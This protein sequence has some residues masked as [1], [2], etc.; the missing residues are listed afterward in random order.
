MMPNR[1]GRATLGILLSLWLLFLMFRDVDW[2]IFGDR[3]VSVNPVF[4][5]AA[6]LMLCADY[7]LRM[8][9]WQRMLRRAGSPIDL[10]TCA[11][12][13]FIGF[14]LN[15]LLPLRAGDIARV[16][17][18]RET[19]GLSGASILATLIAERLLDLLVLLA[20]LSISLAWLPS[21]AGT[22][23]WA[24][25]LGWVAGIALIAIVIT[26]FALLPVTRVAEGLQRLLRRAFGNERGKRLADRL[27]QLRTALMLL[28]NPRAL[29]GFMA[30]SI[31]T[32]LLEGAVFAIVA[33]MLGQQT[34][35][36]WLAMA[37][38][39]LGTLL[40]GAPGHL[41]TFDF[42]AMQG[43]M[44]VGVE[45]ETAAAFALWVHAILWLPVTLMGLA[46]IPF[47]PRVKSKAAD[48]L[49]R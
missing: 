20:V 34:T 10:K 40:P 11:R 37:A 3:L 4:P 29:A 26:G 27:E 7:C 9:R 49:A 36:V 48:E 39:N 35:G 1:Q 38:G 12:P 44:A 18:F 30:L 22:A 14:A 24:G 33:I 16:V 5:L 45:H 17:G 21:G 32:W 2:R 8:L 46:L 43:L 25:K 13:F 41:G 6:I 23:A 31:A 47:G 15:N 42:F 28:G 19:I